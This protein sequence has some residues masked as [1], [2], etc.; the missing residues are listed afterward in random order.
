MLR[1]LIIIIQL[2]DFTLNCTLIITGS[3]AKDALYI[4]FSDLLYA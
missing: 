3:S 1:I 4:V 2:A